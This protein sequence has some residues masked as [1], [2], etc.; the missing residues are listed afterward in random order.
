MH[1]LS[2]NGTLDMNDQAPSPHAGGCLCGAVRYAASAAPM[3][4]GNCHCRDCQKVSGGP[5][6][7]T[8]FF[9]EDTVVIT[10]AVQYY[11]SMGGSGQPIRRGFCPACGSQLFGR[12]SLRTGMLGIRAGTLD[13]PSVYQPQAEV[14]VGHA[15][16]W[17][18]MLEG[19]AKFD[20]YPPSS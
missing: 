5:Y 20:T 19:T 18:R 4:Q 9:A 12:P 1:G 2:P 10:G 8:L 3:L 16:P 11:E 7:P 14:F 15:A 6:A 13:D 17:D